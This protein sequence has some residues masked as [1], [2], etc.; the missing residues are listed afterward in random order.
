M[1]VKNLTRS[2]LTCDTP[3]CGGT[4]GGDVGYENS[5]TAHCEAYAAGW[6][7]PSKTTPD[8]TLIASTSDV[9]PKCV[10]TWVRVVDGRTVRG[11]RR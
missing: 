10:P 1:T 7:F 2:I 6:R 4:F 3:G 9:C 8:G 5:M 11:A